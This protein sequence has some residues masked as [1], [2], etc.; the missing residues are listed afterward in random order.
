M[1][2]PKGSKL[3]E[4][5]KR[6]LSIA[7]K[8]KKLPPFSE[9]HKR[10]IGEAN[11]GRSTWTKGIKFTEEHKHRIS[12]SHMGSKHWRWYGGTPECIDCKKQLTDYRSKR[13]SKCIS[14]FLSGENHWLFGKH[15]SKETKAK[16]SKSLIGRKG[17]RTFGKNS[18]GWIDGRSPLSGL[19]RNSFENREWIDKIFKRDNYTCQTCTKRGGDLEAHHIKQFHNILTEF[20]QEYNQFSPFEDKETLARL[21]MTY[22]PF[23]DID[24]GETLCEECHR[25]TKKRRS[26]V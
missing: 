13:C 4:E 2:R 25:V 14:K 6:N 7:R 26:K 17:V 16:M 3:T 20:L 22:K 5:H 18:P 9:E 1:G 23:W 10:K 19:I 11:K 15:L 8:G 12:E 24:N 21:A